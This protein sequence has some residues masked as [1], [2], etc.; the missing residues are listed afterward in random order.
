MSGENELLPYNKV[1]EELITLCS[2][3]SSGNFNL[4]TDQKHAAVITLNKGDIVGLRYRISQGLEAVNH[5][6]EII[7]AKVRFVQGN[8]YD[9]TQIN[10]TLPSTEDLLKRLGVSLAGAALQ[11]VG[12]KVMVVED[13]GTQR[14][15]IVRMLESAGYRTLEAHD[16]LSALAVLGVEKPEMILLD[17]VMP[18]I[19]GYQVLETIREK[20]GLE[21]T[22]VIM[23][24]SRDGLFDKVRGKMSGSNEYLTKPFKQDE[25]MAKI[26]KYLRS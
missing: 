21:K 25:L 16:G 19:D 20:D 12:K 23:L 3:R 14:K 8:E 7:K 17:I 18:G 22:P 6:K 11:G 26:N 9:T 24:T 2:D 1:M 4:F 15:A 5:I 13:S 10:I